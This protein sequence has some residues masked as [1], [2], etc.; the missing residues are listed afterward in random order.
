MCDIKI[1]QN[2]PQ[3]D[4]LL[5][6]QR[7]YAFRPASIIRDHISLVLWTISI[8]IQGYKSTNYFG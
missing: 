7:L 3:E 2:T 5:L 6:I 8:F 1:P 4:D